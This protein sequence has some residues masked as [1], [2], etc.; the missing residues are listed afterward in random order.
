MTAYE[1]IAKRKADLFNAEVKRRQDNGT[2]DAA[3][4]I[5]LAMDAYARAIGEE[6]DRLDDQ[7]Q[8]ASNKW[9]SPMPG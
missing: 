3:A 4:V 5:G 2:W 9:D 8:G 7:R 6:I 1:R